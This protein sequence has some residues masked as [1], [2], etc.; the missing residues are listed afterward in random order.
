MAVW[1]QLLDDKYWNME[2]LSA[3]YSNEIN[4]STI[5]NQLAKSPL[6]SP[7]FKNTSPTS[8]STLSPDYAINK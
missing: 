2:K 8:V 3:I 6:Y 1:G 5:K 7:E 4:N